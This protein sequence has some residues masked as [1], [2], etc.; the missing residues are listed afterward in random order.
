MFPGAS[1]THSTQMTISQYFFLPQ[2]PISPPQNITQQQKQKHSADSLI[3]FHQVHQDQ[4]S[5]LPYTGSFLNHGEQHQV[6]SLTP[7]NQINSSTRVL[8]LKLLK[9]PTHLP[10]LKFSLFTGIFSRHSKPGTSPFS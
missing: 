9:L 7:R 5:V 1:P 10:L 2:I 4:A 6:N 3:L 8:D